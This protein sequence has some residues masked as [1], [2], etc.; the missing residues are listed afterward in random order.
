MP[1]PVELEHVRRTEARL[2]ASFPQGFVARMLAE[3]GGEVIIGE[4]TWSLNPFLDVSDKVRL[5]RTCYDIVQETKS[6]REWRRFP[7]SAVSIASNGM[8]DHLI[9]LEDPARPGHLQA[10]V[11][12][13]SHETGEC[14]RVVDDFSELA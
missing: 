13:W 9:L 3:N 4:E 6:A 5:K 12:M 10:A 1:F 11:F 2:G 8:G 14:D 7:P